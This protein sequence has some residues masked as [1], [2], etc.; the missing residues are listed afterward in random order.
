M[1]AETLRRAASLMRER[2][3]DAAEAWGGSGW[4]AGETGHDDRQGLTYDVHVGMA[5]VA[6]TGCEELAEHI[7][8][9]HPAVALAVA[10]WLD[11]MAEAVET[12]RAFVSNCHREI[13]SGREC[14]CSTKDCY[15]CGQ[16]HDC[17]HH[18]PRFDEALTV[19]RAYLGESA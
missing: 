18:E 6:T 2:A 8:S 4:T 5:L 7:A 15:E 12:H 3:N 13:E 9:W 10:D 14:G 17:H 1:S 16:W 19:A 11:V